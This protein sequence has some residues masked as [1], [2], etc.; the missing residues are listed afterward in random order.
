[1]ET[2]RQAIQAV[3]RNIGPLLVYL[4]AAFVAVAAAKGSSLLIGEPDNPYKQPATLLLSILVSLL[5]S[6]ITAAFQATIFARMGKEIDRPLWKSAGDWEALRK[7]MALWTGLNLLVLAFIQMFHFAITALDNEAVGSFFLLL[8]AMAT[9][10]YVPFGAAMMFGGD[11]SLK[12]AGERLTPLMR[13]MPQTLAV[14]LLSGMVF[15]FLHMLLPQ[16]QS[17]P[18]LLPLLAVIEA[19]FNCVVFAAVWLICVYDRQNPEETE[20]DF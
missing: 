3:Q 6:L 7:Y 1:M 8:Y 11:V 16:T 4:A 15:V 9:V 12:R 18:W 20:I 10:L 13:Q 14:L 2:L 17:Q 19:Y 5:L